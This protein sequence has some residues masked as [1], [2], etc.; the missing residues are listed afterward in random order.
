MTYQLANAKVWDGSEWVAA[1]QPPWFTPLSGV[2]V[3]TGSA[4]VTADTIAHT[5][6]AWA[7]LVASTSATVNYVA[8]QVS[9]IFV[10]G[11]NTATL[12]DI[13]VGPAGSEQVIAADVGVGGANAVPA[14][15][16]IRYS[17]PVQIPAGSRLSARI[18]SIITGG[19]T[20]TVNAELY[21]WGSSGD[22]GTTVDTLGS[23][24]ADS[25]GLA[26]SGAS[27]TYVQAIASTSKDYRAVGLVGSVNGNQTSNLTVTYT[28]AVGSSGS[29]I[30]FGSVQSRYT[31]SENPSSYATATLPIF[32]RDIP[33]GSRL[34]IKHDI[35]GGPTNY[36]CTVIGIP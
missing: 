17:L 34:A 23:N 12:V 35:G 4:T 33:A 16:G 20:A 19:K 28:V 2:P 9:Q 13:A 6:G 27:G 36:G 7:E 3:N 8:V 21:S 14:T 29:E 24:T 5:K 18:Q 1:V 11:S 10:S 15:P 32:A 31:T 25:S 22:I 26:M 30:D